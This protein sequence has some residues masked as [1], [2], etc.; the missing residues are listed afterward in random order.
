[1]KESEFF[2]LLLKKIITVVNPPYNKIK[3][4]KMSDI[5]FLNEI[6]NYSSVETLKNLFGYLKFNMFHSEF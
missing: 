5:Q 1:M 2:D 4:L 6:L 3:V